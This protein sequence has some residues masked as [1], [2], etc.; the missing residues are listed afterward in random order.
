MRFALIALLCVGA[1]LAYNLTGGSWRSMPVDYTVHRSL[2][3]DVSDEQAMEAMLMGHQVWNDLP[4]SDLE[5]NLAGRTDNTGWGRR[6][7]ENAVTWRESNWGDSGGALAITAWSGGRSGLTDADI[8][9]N[10]VHHTWSHDANGVRGRTDIASVAAHEVGHAHG[11]SH[12][13]VRGSTMWPSVS[14]GDVDSRTLGPDDIAG[15][16]AI[17]DSGEPI[18]DPGDLPPPSAGR[19]DFGEDCSQDQCGAG[20]VCLRSSGARYCSRLC[21]PNGPACEAGYHCSLLADHYG[22]CALGPDPNAGRG[23]VGEACGESR[24]CQR[25]LICIRDLTADYCAAPCASG[26]PAD[27][28]C[29]ALSDGRQVCARP[30][31]QNALPGAGQPCLGGHCQAGMICLRE[32]AAD[33]CALDCDAA[34]CPSGYS[35]VDL[36]PSGRAC[37]LNGAPQSA[38]PPQAAPEHVPDQAPAPPPVAPQGN[39]GGLPR[40]QEACS[41][42][43]RQPACAVGLVCAGTQVEGNEVLDPGFCTFV[44]N[45]E[46]CCP[47]GWGCV[48]EYG[49]GRCHPGAPSSAGL[50]CLTPLSELP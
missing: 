6:D 13:N 10:G 50:E 30:L 34:A 8:K 27:H 37:T 11:L 1:A 42:V 18:P 39:H 43:P 48:M 2:S 21:E 9:F 17:Y 19:A 26:C 36:V 22:A 33:V 40:L 23:Q 38:P 35:C 44:C 24:G 31:D 41:T 5:W 4:C 14:S 45:A 32:G 46:S 28:A 29:T 20:L 3:A 15:T 12:S 49:S 16:C 25:G 7:G 47:S